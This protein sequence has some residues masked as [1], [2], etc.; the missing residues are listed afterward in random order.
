MG[1]RRPGGRQISQPAVLDRGAEV[2]NSPAY[3]NRLRS[4]SARQTPARRTTEKRRVGVAIRP[5]SS[6][7]GADSQRKWRRRESNPR[8]VPYARVPTGWS[9]MKVRLRAAARRRA[10]FASAM[11]S[12]GA[13][14]SRPSSRGSRG[15][16][17]GSRRTRVCGAQREYVQGR[18]VLIDVFADPQRVVDAELAVDGHCACGGL[19]RSELVSS[20]GNAITDRRV[21]SVRR[22]Q[23]GRRNNFRTRRR[24]RP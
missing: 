12:D 11:A 21:A 22:G 6:T 16:G 19:R 23:Y 9:L 7:E 17:V 20:V 13:E 1:N 10:S 8:R 18:P 15:D 5:S 3:G 4:S 24:S 14:T 2:T